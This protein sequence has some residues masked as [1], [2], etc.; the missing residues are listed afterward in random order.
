MARLRHDGGNGE[1]GSD[2]L[3]VEDALEQHGLRG[4]GAHVRVG[5]LLRHEDAANLAQILVH[6]V[7]L[8]LDGALA[9]VEDL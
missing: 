6:F 8:H 7:H 1:H 5:R 3:A 4:L 9:D 2:D